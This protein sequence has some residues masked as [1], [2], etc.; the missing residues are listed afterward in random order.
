MRINLES[1]SDN[2][3][4]TGDLSYKASRIINKFFW[5]AYLLPLIWI[6]TQVTESANPVEYLVH[7]TGD[8]AVYFLVGVLWLS[9]LRILLG[10]R[11]G[12]GWIKRLQSHRRG[13]GLASAFYAILHFTLHVL[14]NPEWEILWKDLQRVYL[15]TGFLA[16]L[17]LLILALTS[18]NKM[19]RKLGANHWK[20]I[21]RLIYFAA[22][23]AAIHLFLNEK[24]SNL[25]ALIL[26]VPLAA[27]EFL[28]LGFWCYGYS[29]K[30]R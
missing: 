11:S 25:Q 14:D 5:I 26:F 6:G 16:F 28:R 29:Q 3:C 30:E 20:N 18:S 27:A 4:L 9:P 12:F 23:L 17:I 21:H 1:C 2:I 24:S 19:V 15:L 13:I 22:G 8:W 10:R 7:A